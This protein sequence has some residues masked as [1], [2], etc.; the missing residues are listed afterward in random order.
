MG[1][2]M[3]FELVGRVE[4]K[5]ASDPSFDMGCLLLVGIWNMR[6]GSGSKAAPTKTERSANACDGPHVS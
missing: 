3:D 2:A 5:C 6:L 4:T 1:N